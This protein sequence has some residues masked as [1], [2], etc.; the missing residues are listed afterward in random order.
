MEHIE[1]G[2]AGRMKDLCYGC[3]Q[4]RVLKKRSSDGK[5]LCRRCLRNQSLNDILK[6]KEKKE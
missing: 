3:S 1:V 6:K 2:G 4:Y 5:L